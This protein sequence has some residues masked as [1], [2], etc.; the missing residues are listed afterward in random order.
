M[1]SVFVFFIIF[2][3]FIY[4]EFL[5][6]DS[7]FVDLDEPMPP[8]PLCGLAP[9]LCH[10]GLQLATEPKSKLHFAVLCGCD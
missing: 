8:W 5:T 10:A 6:L 1:V 9:S 4:S 7:P 3:P 2:K